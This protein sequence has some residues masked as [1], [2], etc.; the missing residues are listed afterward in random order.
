MITEVCIWE[1]QDGKIT[2]FKYNNEI[3]ILQSCQNKQAD[4]PVKVL[5]LDLNIPHGKYTKPHKRYIN[6][7]DRWIK[8]T[9]MQKFSL[10]ELVSA[11]PALKSTPYRINL[12]ISKMIEDKTLTQ[13]DKD[14]FLVNKKK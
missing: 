8:N 10:K 13:I 3:F 7:I 2:A 12:Y 14:V 11:I 1:M 4:E 5:D 9:K 6:K